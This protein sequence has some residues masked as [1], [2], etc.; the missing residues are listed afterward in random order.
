MTSLHPDLLACVHDGILQHPLL[1][2]RAYDKRFLAIYNREYQMKLTQLQQAEATGN[3]SKTVWLYERQ[4]RTTALQKVAEFLNDYQ[5]W[6][7]VADVWLDADVTDTSASSTRIWANL[8]SA[9]RPCRDRVMTD[10]EHRALRLIPDDLVLIYGTRT[11]SLSWALSAADAKSLA[12]RS[13]IDR[14][15]I[16]GMVQKRHIQAFFS[17]ARP[18]RYEDEVVVLPAYCHFEKTATRRALQPA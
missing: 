5:Y 8:W 18:G 3:W 13:G 14:P 7:M 1:P 11:V 17:R 2:K 16:T 4:F 9:D 12:E 10:E 15:V 6:G